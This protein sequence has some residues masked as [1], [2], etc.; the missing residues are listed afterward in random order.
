VVCAAINKAQEMRPYVG[1]IMLDVHG[2][3]WE[4]GKQRDGVLWDVSH[5]LGHIVGQLR[6]LGKGV[7]LLHDGSAEKNHTEAHDRR[8]QQVYQVVQSLVDWLMRE[9]FQFV[10]LDA[11]VR[12][13]SRQTSK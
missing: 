3:D 4:L 8:E 12:P 13:G 11:V 6:K 9:K 10:A 7:V 1:P 5:C 2:F